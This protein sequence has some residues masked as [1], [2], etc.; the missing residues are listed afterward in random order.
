[1]FWFFTSCGCTTTP[2][3]AVPAGIINV[4]IGKSNAVPG[5]YTVK[6]F[7]AG[8][9]VVAAIGDSWINWKKIGW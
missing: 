5:G 7:P 8:T 4:T 3:R 2:G 9:D 1:M 6:L